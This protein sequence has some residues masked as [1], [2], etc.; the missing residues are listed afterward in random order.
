[1]SKETKVRRRSDVGE[2]MLIRMKAGRN[3]IVEATYRMDV[4]EFRVFATM[5][6]MINPG[7]PAFCEYEI[8]V[9]D[10]IRV[11]NMSRDGRS[12]ETLREAAERLVSK[13]MVI[14]HTKE[15]G[16]RYRTVVPFLASASSPVESRQA[17]AIRVS[18]HPDLRPYL[19]QLRSEYLEFDVRNVARVQSQYSLRLYMML[20]H[21]INLKKAYVRYTVERL[22]E[23]FEL[24]DKEYPLYG[25]FKQKILL[26]AQQ[27]LN[28]FTNIRITKLEEERSGRKIAAVVFHLEEQALT[29]TF[30]PRRQIRAATNPENQLALTL[31]VPEPVPAANTPDPV[32]L[33]ERVKEYVTA[34]TVRS[35]LAAYP[36][37][38]VEVA[39]DHTLQR[40][41]KG[42]AIRNV[43]GYLAKMVATP[44]G[45]PVTGSKKTPPVKKTPAPREQAEERHRQQQLALFERE[46]NTAY[47][48]L[49]QHPEWEAAVAEQ[50]QMGLF[51]RLYKREAP[52]QENIQNPSLSGP[53]IE[54]VRRQDPGAFD[55]LIE[56]NG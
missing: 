6:T 52:F 25:N 22:R 43:G 51:G 10:I 33:H 40:I 31:P 39:I 37:S 20:R 11:F 15:D 50:M 36:P 14:Y 53:F 45:P 38:Q 8:R 26:R 46:L 7:D 23:I 17:E 9:A 16:Q 34:E 21:Q 32:S 54:A 24:N 35:W 13:T 29:L 49:L 30:P 12:Y 41:H 42:D 55:A 1:M 2:R 48:L 4:T 56:E 27:D 19:L 18:F 5:L 28:E 3:G 47:S 44:I